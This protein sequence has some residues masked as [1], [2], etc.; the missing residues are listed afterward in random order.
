MRQ[1]VRLPIQRLLVGVV[2]NANSSTQDE[3]HLEDLFFFV[4]DDILFFLVAKV[5]RFESKG[6]IV[7]EFTLL[8]LLGIKEE[9]EVVEDVIEE[10][11]NDDTALDLSWESIDE[12]IVL[13]DLTESIVSP[14]VFEM[15]IDLAVK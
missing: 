1:V 15:L 6:H 7:Q 8:V 12:L 9:P 2:T 13:L 4:I 14:K 5:A 3:V 11:V 10:I